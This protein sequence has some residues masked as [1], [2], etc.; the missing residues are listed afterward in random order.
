MN[1]CFGGIELEPHRAFYMDNILREI[2]KTKLVSLK[3]TAF[4]DGMDRVYLCIHGSTEFQRV[5]QKRDGGSDGI[6]NGDTV[7]AA[8]APEKYSLADFKKKLKMISAHI[9][10]TGLLLI[11]DGE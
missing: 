11:W 4:Q 7:L 3:G 1:E 5:K 10:R 9:V 2:I 8:Y 6:L